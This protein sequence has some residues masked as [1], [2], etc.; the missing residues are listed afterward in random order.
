MQAGYIL[1]DL[2]VQPKEQ[3]EVGRILRLN[4]HWPLAMSTAGLPTRQCA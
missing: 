3:A 1:A 4:M 2:G